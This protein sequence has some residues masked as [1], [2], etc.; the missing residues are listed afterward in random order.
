MSERVCGRDE[1]ATFPESGNG[2][3]AWVCWMNLGLIGG[4]EE[5]KELVSAVSLTRAR[6]RTGGMGRLVEGGK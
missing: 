4:V 5:G 3:G 6:R 2:L 1:L